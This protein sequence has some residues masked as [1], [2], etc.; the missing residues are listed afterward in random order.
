MKINVFNK[1]SLQEKYKKEVVPAMMKEFG[2]K[3]VMAVPKIKKVI[4]NACF[5]KEVASKTSQERGKT[6]QNVSQDLAAISG[7]KPKIVKSKKSIS[8]FKLRSGID[9]ASMVTLRKGKMYDFLERFINLTL[10][11]TRDFK[12]INP[13]SVDK[14]GNLTIG[15]REHIAFSEIV[16]EREKTIFGLEV[17]VATNAKNKEEGLRLLKLMGFPIKT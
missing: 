6:A 15:F 9:I 10:P 8:G 2:Y 11:R 4:I 14:K 3:N 17:T 12:G 13:K 7:Q 5:G 16:A 1:M